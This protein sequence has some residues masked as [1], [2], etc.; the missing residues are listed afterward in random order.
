MPEAAANAIDLDA[1]DRLRSLFLRRIPDFG[2]FTDRVGEY[3]N[4]EREYKEQICELVAAEFPR[5]LFSDLTS[6]EAADAIVKATLRALTRR[7]RSGDTTMPQNLVGWRYVEFLRTL[8]IEDKTQF[9][10]A[11]G[12]LLHG[13]DQEPERVERFTGQV[14]ELYRPVPGQNRYALSRIFPTFFLMFMSPRSNIA[15]RSEMFESASKQLLGRSILSAEPFNAPGYREV[16]AFSEAVFRQ[17][18]SW[19][20]RPR[21][22]IDV[23]SFLWIV[24]RPSSDSAKAHDSNA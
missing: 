16:L 15:V 20:W 12:D 17:L 24:T 5:V 22:M 9:A 6:P 11:L 14:W 7:V 18:Q 4:Q 3:W 2:D 21:D 13:E 8:R 19:A 1:L 23:H 10:V